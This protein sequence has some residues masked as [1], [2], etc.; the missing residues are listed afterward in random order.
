MWE[1]WVTKDVS[2][3]KPC[4]KPAVRESM[5][6]QGTF[7]VRKRCWQ[8]VFAL[9][10]ISLKDVGLGSDKKTMSHVRRDLVKMKMQAAK[11]LA[12]IKEKR[13]TRSLR[14]AGP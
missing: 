3:S 2:Q 7:D 14:W 11:V 1:W 10:R 9:Q 8:L 4:C 13:C 6:K 5:P 12:Q